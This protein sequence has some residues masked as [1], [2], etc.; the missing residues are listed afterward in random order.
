MMQ[1]MDSIDAFLTNSAIPEDHPLITCF[2]GA[3]PDVMENRVKVLL[4]KVDD[5]TIRLFQ[6]D[7]IHS[8]LILF[9]QGELPE[10]M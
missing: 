8:P 7:V 3:Y 9:E 4:T 5:A 1:V 10:L 2:A 6:K